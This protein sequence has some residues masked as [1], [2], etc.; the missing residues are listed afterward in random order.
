MK[1]LVL[2]ASGMLGHTV[3]RTLSEHVETYGTVRARDEDVHAIAPSAAGVLEGVAA[4]DFDTIVGAVAR[5]QPDAIVNCIGIVKQLDAGKAAVPSIAVNSLFPHRLHGLARVSGS[6]L[7]HVSTDCVFSGDRGGYT[8][9]DLPDAVDLYGRSK[10]LGEV[11]DD[12]ALTIRTSII[13]R[14][15]R[16][17]H[18]LLE[19][20]LSQ[21]G[22]EVRGF[23]RAIFSGWTTTA[24]SRVILELITRQP[25]LVGLWHVAAEPIDKFTL[26]QLVRDAFDLDVS[27]R[28]DDEVAIDRSLDGS[29]F[30]AE[31]GIAAPP[32]PVM[33]AELAEGSST[34]DLMRGTTVASR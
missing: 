28:R 13:G 25:P 30:R 31:T 27:I 21:Q 7:V 11:V 22:R 1:A 6:Q 23:S 18:G 20:F 12:R 19:W 32:W 26:L 29:R 8:E 16:G 34:Y 5:T 14:E 4:T 24:L 15:L 2:G 10:L 33:I 9:D 17:A 3:L